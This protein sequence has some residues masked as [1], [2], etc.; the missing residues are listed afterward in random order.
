VPAR[1]IRALRLIAL[2]AQPYQD[3]LIMNN[4]PLPRHAT[5]LSERALASALLPT[6]A[7]D[8]TIRDTQAVTAPLAVSFL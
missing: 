2:F 4:F 8:A 3:H 1:A 5:L 7:A 6:T